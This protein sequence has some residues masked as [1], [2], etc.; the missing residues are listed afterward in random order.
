MKARRAN[1]VERLVLQALDKAKL[2]NVIR[3]A[4]VADQWD[5]RVL[6]RGWKLDSL[7]ACLHKVVN[8]MR[9]PVPGLVIAKPTTVFLAPDKAARVIARAIL[10]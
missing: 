5:L 4:V 7:R 6:V 3:L 8:D 2:E 10:A 1:N 9:T